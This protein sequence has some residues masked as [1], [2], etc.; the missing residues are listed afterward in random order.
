M[1][2]DGR[3]RKPLLAVFG[4]RRPW[5][6]PFGP[7]TGDVKNR[8]WRFFH[9]ASPRPAT[10]GGAGVIHNFCRKCR[11]DLVE[12]WRARELLLAPLPASGYRSPRAIRAIALPRAKA[13]AWNH[14]NEKAP[15]ERGFGRAGGA[16]LRRC[17][18]AQV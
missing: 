2:I 5:R 11:T 1:S 4:S 16:S 9:H 13:H 15:P 18:Q 12:K 8:S 6:E 10:Q 7:S 14:E 17:A 3:C